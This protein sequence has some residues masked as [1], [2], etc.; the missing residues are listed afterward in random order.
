MRARVTAEGVT[1][2]PP[3]HHFTDATPE[4]CLKPLAKV[5]PSATLVGIQGGGVQLQRLLA[6]A[7]TACLAVGVVVLNPTIAHAAFPGTNGVV[8]YVT[9]RNQSDTIELVNPEAG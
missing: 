2:G 3:H 4:L 1:P 7:G 9:T 6:A 8:A 5:A